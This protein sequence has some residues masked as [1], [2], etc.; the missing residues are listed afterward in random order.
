MSPEPRK[1]A[2]SALTVSA[3]GNTLPP[4]FICRRVKFRAHFLNGARAGSQRVGSHPGW[5]KAEHFVKFVKHFVPHMKPSRE[6]PAVLLSSH[7]SRLS[8]TALD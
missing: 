5:M 2:T 3:T 7:D 1:L 4:L 6:R 8:V